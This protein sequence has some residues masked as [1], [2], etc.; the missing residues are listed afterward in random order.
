MK[1][2]S[3]CSFIVVN[4]L[5][6]QQL[7]AN[8]AVVCWCIILNF[9]NSDVTKI[10]SAFLWS[11]FQNKLLVFSFGYVFWIFFWLSAAN[12]N[13]SGHPHICVTVHPYNAWINSDFHQPVTLFLF[14]LQRPLSYLLKLLLVWN[15]I[16]LIGGK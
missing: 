13:C 11:W 9:G 10:W 6:C 15:S 7:R 1:V 8:V 3:E 12:I 16:H 14:R 4:I 5:T 2:Y